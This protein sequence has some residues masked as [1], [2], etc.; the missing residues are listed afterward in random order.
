MDFEAHY[1][2]AELITDRSYWMLGDTK[3]ISDYR[4][5]LAIDKGVGVRK[6]DQLFI[7]KEWL[8]NLS[9]ARTCLLYTSPSPRD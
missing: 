6:D 2:G 5:N 1:E 3:P 9:L 4:A 8:N 7:S